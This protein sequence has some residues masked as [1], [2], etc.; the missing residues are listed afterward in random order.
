M[1]RCYL[2]LVSFPRLDGSHGMGRIE[3]EDRS[4]SG[5]YSRT[6]CRSAVDCVWQPDVREGDL[7]ELFKSLNVLSS[8]ARLYGHFGRSLACGRRGSGRGS[9]WQDGWCESSRR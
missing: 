7:T 6:R 1:A 5:A 8:S 2:I 4:D 9:E 3:N